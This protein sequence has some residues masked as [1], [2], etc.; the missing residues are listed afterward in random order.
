MS[1]K[2]YQQKRQFDQTPEPRGK[3]AKHDKAAIFVVH[4]HRARNLHY[5]FRLEMDGVLKSWAVPKGP[6]LNPADKRL[7]MMVEDHPLEYADFE[8]TIPEGQYGAGKV[9]IWDKGRVKFINRDL[10]GGHLNFILDGQKLNGEFTLVKIKKPRTRS[11]EPWLLIKVA[12]KKATHKPTLTDEVKVN[13][14]DMPQNIKPMLATLVDKPFD[15]KGWL[16]EIKWDGYRAIA[17]ID[18]DIKLYSRYGNLFNDKYPEIVEGL[19]KVGHRAV[20]DGEIV[21]LDAEGRSQFQLLQDYQKTHR[22]NLLYYVF[23]ILWL[24]GR[25]LRKLPLWERKK[26]LKSTLP[27][28]KNIKYSDHIEE[29]GKKFFALAIKKNIEGIMAKDGSSPYL[30][31]RTKSWLKIKNVNEQEVIIGG[32]TQPRQ[33][34]K[35]FGALVLG[36]YERGKLIYVGHSG[37][38]F[39]EA[40]LADLYDKMKPLITKECPFKIEP[41]TNEPA[42]WLKPKLVAQVKF[43]EWTRDGIMRQP[44]FL[45]LREDKSAK[46][47]RREGYHEQ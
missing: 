6:S 14:S 31:G 23:D 1:L 45:G 7:A 26:I 8:G 36:V 27:E 17:E 11:G 22:G 28:I 19:K 38:G 47:V 2:Q 21:A 24:D 12:D 18:K 44:I 43:A 46:E 33:S 25:D 37:S 3:I 13:R 39:D 41:K 32:F 40:S 10:S 29:K 35:Y 34:R 4:K 9:E 16:F 20:L 30:S 42:T 5:D 15:R